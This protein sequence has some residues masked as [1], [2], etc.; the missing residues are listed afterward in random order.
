MDTISPED[1]EILTGKLGSGA[2]VTW[3][4]FFQNYI[5]QLYPE[6]NPP[7]LQD[8][9]ERQDHAL[10]TKGREIGTQ[11]ERHMKTFIIDQLQ[12][13]FGEDWDIEIG[14]IQRDCEVR[15]KEQME[16]NF[17]DGLGRKEIPWTDQFFIT[18]YKTIIENYWTKRPANSPN[19]ESFED[20]FAIDVGHG[21]NS[22]AEKIKWISLFNTLRNNWA[23]AGTKEKGL[24]KL[25]VELLTKI[26]AKLGLAP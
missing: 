16:K 6:Y 15:A 22:K 4:R 8:W 1:S 10:Q 26:H 17:K 5:N 21:F 7:E 9:R 25:D 13:L 20:H 2:E 23:H 18:D 11:I 14:K 12:A 19:S 3:L 24:N